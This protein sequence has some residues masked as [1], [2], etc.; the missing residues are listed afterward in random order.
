[1]PKAIVTSLGYTYYTARDSD[2]N[3]ARIPNDNAMQYEE[4][5]AAA[6]AAL[7]RKMKWHGRY[8][9]AYLADGKR[10]WV[11]V[12]SPLTDFFTVEGEQTK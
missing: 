1:M 2:G 9:G 12:D 4:K 3:T 11:D 10:V 7:C 6:A 8:A 5:H